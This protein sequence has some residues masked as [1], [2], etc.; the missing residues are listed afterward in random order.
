MRVTRKLASK[1]LHQA[2]R[3]N[4]A[5]PGASRI[6]PLI[7]PMARKAGRFRFQL[8]IKSNQRALLHREVHQLINWMERSREARKTRWSVDIDPQDMS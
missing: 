7:A 2:C 5:T 8:I 1:L 6:G 4:R 3:E